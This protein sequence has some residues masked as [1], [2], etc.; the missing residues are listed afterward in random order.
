MYQEARKLHLIEDLLKIKS[1]TVLTELETI[2]K[3]A[4]RTKNSKTV[5]AHDFLELIS[6]EDLLLM[7]AA[8][9][10]GC[11]QANPDDWK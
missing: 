6:K 1:E 11:E 9:Q 3:R 8:I 7:D 5:S 4:M 10:E 2:V